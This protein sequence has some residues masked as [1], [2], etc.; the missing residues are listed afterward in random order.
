M[1]GRCEAIWLA[2]WDRPSIP[3][4]RIGSY[5]YDDVF[6]ILESVRTEVY[7]SSPQND[8]WFL[9]DK[10][11]VHSSHAV[12]CREVFHEPEDFI[13]QGFWGEITVPTSWQH[14]RPALESMRYYDLAYGTVYWVK[15]RAEDEE[16]RAWYRI[17][18]DLGP[19]T[20]WWVQAHHV[21]RVEEHEF[22]PISSGVENKRILIDLGK[23]ELTAYEN[24]IPVFETRIAS[25][26]NFTDDEGNLHYF[27]T[28]P[29]DYVIERKK[30]SRRMVGGAEADD[31]FDLPGVPWV[32]YFTKKGAAIHGTYWHNDYGRPRSHGCINVT[33]DAAKWVYR[34]VW[35]YAGYDEE[36]YWTQPEDIATEIIII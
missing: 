19:T 13:G 17:V 14:W 33:N 35:P 9:T 25:G 27:S 34:W 3:A 21:R 24:G 2:V 7:W 6:P 10:G 4:E 30:P 18:D 1:L 32:S 20:A 16:G 36:Y 12:P 26:T 23:Q 29:G 28:A 22:D 15:D 31:F 5:L 11:W 8:V